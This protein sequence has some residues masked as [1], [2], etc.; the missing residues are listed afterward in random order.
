MHLTGSAVLQSGTLK[1]VDPRWLSEGLGSC[2][3]AAESINTAMA[4]TDKDNLEACRI[5]NDRIMRVMTLL[6]MHILTP[7]WN[8]A[9]PKT[10]FG[11]VN[12]CRTP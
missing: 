6:V 12:V 2:V 9:F 4:N 1:D 5:L 3:R 10:K 8:E 11:F 7:V